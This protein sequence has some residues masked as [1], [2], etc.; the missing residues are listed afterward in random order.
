VRDSSGVPVAETDYLYDGG[1]I[2]SGSSPTQHD[3]QYS[4][5]FTAPRA[6]VTTVT[7]L[8]MQSCSNSVIHYGY[9][10][11]GQAVTKI[12]DANQT[13]TY[14]FNDNPPGGNS[15]G[16]SNAYLT[17]IT[18][19]IANGIQ[20]QVS[21]AYSYP[22]GEPTAVQDA[23]GQ[24]TGYIYSD[25]LRRL[26]EIDYAN[27]G[28]ATFDYHADALPLTVSQTK[29]ATPD[30]SITNS[31]V[32][33][34][35]GRISQTRTDTDPDTTVSVEYA[36]DGLNRIHSQ[37]NP[38]RSTSAPTDGTTQID[39]DGTGRITKVTR[40]GGNSVVTT[41]SANCST[42]TDEAARSRKSCF[43]ALGRLTSVVEPNPA[44]GSLAAGTSYFTAYSYNAVDK[45][46]TVSQQGDGTLT[47]RNRAFTYDSLSRVTSANNPET[48]TVNYTYDSASDCPAPNSFP[49]DLVKRVDARGIRTCFRY[50]ALHRLIAKNYSDAT[51]P[52]AYLY[53]QSFYNGLNTTNGIGRRI[54]MSDGTGQTAWSYDVVGN[55]AAK[56]KT[57]SGTT[58]TIFYTYNRNRAVNTLTSPNGHGYTYAYNGS[59]QPVSLND[60]G[61][62]ITYTQNAHYAPP[63]ELATASHGLNSVIA[64]SNVYNNRLQPSVISVSGPS[65]TIF[66]LSYNWVLPGGGD[67]GNVYQ[68]HN[69]RDVTRSVQFSYD[70]LNRL[71]T[72]GTYNVATWGDSYVYD[73]F[74]NLLQKNVTQG[75]AESLQN[76]VDAT[77]RFS[78]GGYLYDAAGNM[79]W[80]N[81]NLNGLSYDAENRMTPAAGGTVY[82][83]DGDNRRV[84]T[85]TG[86][87]ATQFWY[88]DNGAVISTTGAWQRDYVYF[89]AKRLAYF[90]PSTGNQHY[91]W[92]DH[93]G[94][95]SVM[96]NSDGSSIEWESDYYPFGTRRPVY[97]FLDNFF[98]FTGYQFDYE[99]GYYYAGAREQSPSLGRFLSPDPIGI[100][101]QKLG[102][103]QQWNMYAYARNNPLRF[104]DP[105]GL[106]DVDCKGDKKCNK[107][108]DKFEKQRQKDLKSK[109]LKVREAAKA[110]GS[111]G[112]RN[113]IIVTFK[114]QAQ[115]DR[116]AGTRPGYT[117]TGFVTPFGVAGDD[118]PH[119]QAEFSENLGGST[120]GQI[121]A[122]EGSHIEDDMNFLNSYDFTTGK[123]NPVRN[124]THFDTEFQAFEAGSGVKPYSD[125]RRGPKGYQQLEN[126]IR[127]AYDNSDDLVFSPS[128]FPQ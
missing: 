8:C 99:L 102:D 81:S 106:Y 121:I 16:N 42:T 76:S 65:G 116:D 115:V 61:A 13:T 43:D 112:E 22:A 127:Q 109:D 29:L 80:D 33:D 36:Y 34:G 38:H 105:T 4:T 120:L 84:Q 27:G 70:Y 14:S 30:P 23:N 5:S 90:A 3:T 88:D 78:A 111:R 62:G 15:Y 71:G 67:N 68:I 63:G 92:S 1:S 82:S 101:Q 85:I 50:D 86:D 21:V 123:Y 32:Y 20:Q 74:G 64:E 52:V 24:T 119:I 83:Y 35:L 56:R 69:N 58:N 31:T 113:H 77:N 46:R 126:Y 12:D 72:A 98:L 104:V 48:G 28:T 100:M 122:H 7:Q 6:N 9:D 125:F 89:G 73:A 47:S 118:D 44:T 97:S 37:S 79:T 39:Y 103:P 93:L 107:S 66:S 53:D 19:P 55:V 128:R 94:S 96:S 117:T 11:T 75:T 2:A 26:T 91:Y 108:A 59:G 51:S 10:E 87:G 17:H 40:P 114:P 110:W 41:Y 25:S 57:I 95:A 49:G 124:F 18:F 60:V 45:L 54:G